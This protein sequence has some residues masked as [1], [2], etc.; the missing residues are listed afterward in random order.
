MDQQRALTTTDYGLMAAIGGQR[1]AGAPAWTWVDDH[2][3]QIVKTGMHAYAESSWKALEAPAGWKWSVWGRDNWPFDD[4]P[5]TDSDWAKYDTNK[6][7]WLSNGTEPAQPED[8][9]GVYLM[10]AGP[11]SLIDDQVLH[12][13]FDPYDPANGPIPLGVNPI[14]IVAAQHGW[15][16]V[17][18]VAVDYA[19]SGCANVPAPWT[20][21]TMTPSAGTSALAVAGG[22]TAD[23]LTAGPAPHRTPAKGSSRRMPKPDEPNPL[24]ALGVDLALRASLV[25][26]A[27]GDVVARIRITDYGLSP[28]DEVEIVDAK[29]GGHAP[30]GLLPTRRRHI[31]AGEAM[32][33]HLKYAGVPGKPGKQVPLKVRVSYLGGSRAWTL[34]LTLP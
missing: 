4:I 24:P 27:V 22:A 17:G 15:A 9:C 11:H 10:V 28:A 30:I 19:Y 7:L 5:R 21:E 16:Q 29:L 18:S 14:D 12:A 3:D 26:D 13:L 25:R 20:L 2:A 8:F 1:L 34:M 23:A 33:T 32:S 6:W 31:D